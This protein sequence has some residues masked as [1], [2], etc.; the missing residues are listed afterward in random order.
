MGAWPEGDVGSSGSVAVHSRFHSNLHRYTLDG[1]CPRPPPLLAA[2]A[3]YI[4]HPDRL[5]RIYF[6]GT[7]AIPYLLQVVALL[8]HASG[9]RAPSRPAQARAM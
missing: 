8:A 9:S 1:L 4:Y 7:E 3:I 6:H 5:S 2:S